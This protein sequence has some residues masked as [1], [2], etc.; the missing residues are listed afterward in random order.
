MLM[1]LG[2][3]PV[4]RSGSGS[5]RNVNRDI[6]GHEVSPV[7]RSVSVRK[8]VAQK[9]PV[10]RVPYV[11]GFAIGVRYHWLRLVCDATGLRPVLLCY[12]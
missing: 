3:F 1:G 9:G 8:S 4:V 12:Y 6:I 2:P 5:V 7:D 10:V 11:Y